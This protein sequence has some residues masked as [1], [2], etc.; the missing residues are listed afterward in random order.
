MNPATLLLVTALAIPTNVLVLRSGDRIEIQSAHEQDGRMVFRT[1]DGG[2]YSLSLQEIDLVATRT[3]DPVAPAVPVTG[4]GQT[5]VEQKKLKVGADDRKRLLV[6]LEQNHSGRP[7]PPLAIEGLPSPPSLEEVARQTEDEWTWRRRAR[8]LEEVVR[9]AKENRDLLQDRAD[10]LRSHV[11]SL[12]SL[13]YKP[14]QFTYDT[15]QLQYTLEQLPQANLDITRAERALADF[16][17]EAR[18]RGIAPGW[19]R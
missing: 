7:G 9:Q 13:G 5:T 2:L 10:A 8:A 16:R 15:T 12:L 6:E 3:G 14:G 4:H 18:R 1:T 19:V 11:L 17:E